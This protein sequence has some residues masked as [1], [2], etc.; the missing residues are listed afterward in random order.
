[1]VSAESGLRPSSTSWI[2]AMAAPMVMNF[3]GR[4]IRD[5]G[6]TA[7]G[8]GSL[9]QRELPAIRAALPAS[10]SSLFWPR[11]AAAAPAAGPV[12]AQ[13]VTPQ[14]SHAIWP[15]ALGIL[16]LALGLGWLFNHSRRPVMPPQTAAIP[17]RPAPTGEASRLATETD[18]AH[19]QAPV[20]INIKFNTG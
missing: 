8:L 19:R 18:M 4:R 3:L 17:T 11:A 15:A 14:K 6:M 5:E 2:M 9:L 10:L 13:T 16:A 12:I 7:G 1:A 20:N